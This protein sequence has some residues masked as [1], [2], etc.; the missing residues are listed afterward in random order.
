MNPE[1]TNTGAGW[2]GGVRTALSPVE[3]AWEPYRGYGTR[4]F[5]SHST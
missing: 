3:C 5:Y 2:Q 4:Q 1:C